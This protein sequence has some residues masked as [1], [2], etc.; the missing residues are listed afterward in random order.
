MS[1][2]SKQIYTPISNFV[3]NNRDRIDIEANSQQVPD[4][5]NQV[6]ADN[7]NNPQLN[8]DVIEEDVKLPVSFLR[9][10]FPTVW[11]FYRYL[12]DI[13]ML[14]LPQWTIKSKKPKC[15]TEKYLYNILISKNFSVK[16]S[17]I[18]VPP[19]VTKQYPKSGLINWLSKLTELPLGFEYDNYPKKEWII[20]VIYSLK[21]DHEI[22][23]KV[24]DS[25]K[26][27]IPQE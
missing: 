19:V 21:K 18:S 12:V 14:Y 5:S 23:Q 24:T 13:R 26:R 16:S 27:S 9:Q 7:V 25:V 8:L 3:V 20:T 6:N 15:I 17:L 10:K 4:L 2:N 11:E 22:F 1:R